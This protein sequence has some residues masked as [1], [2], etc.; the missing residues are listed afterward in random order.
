MRSGELVSGSMVGFRS[1]EG[2]IRG[3]KVRPSRKTLERTKRDS[4]GWRK[5]QW[6]VG[7]SPKGEGGYGGR[8]N[9]SRWRRS[10]RKEGR[11]SE[12]KMT[13]SEVQQMLDRCEEEAALT[14]AKRSEEIQAEKEARRR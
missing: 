2:G 12:T 8:E 9:E 1:L 3:K 13:P 11:G 14:T 10:A 7:G 6:R 5:K 4:P